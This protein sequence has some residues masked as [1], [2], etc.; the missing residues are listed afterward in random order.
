MVA[1]LK[2]QDA[3]T[4]AYASQYVDDSIESTQMNCGDF[5]FDPV[6]TAHN[7]L[8]AVAW[9]VQKKIHMPFHFLP[10]GPLTSKPDAFVTEPDSA[11]ANS[12]I[13]RALREA[14]PTSKLVALGIAMHSYAD[15]WAH[16]GFVGKD[17]EL[18]DVADIKYKA[19]D[20]WI[21][22]VA[23]NVFL[24]VLPKIGHAQASHYPDLPW[25]EWKYKRDGTGKIMK[26]KN[27]D[28]FMD[29]AEHI[30]ARLSG[31]DEA[32]E[33]KYSWND[34]KDGVADVL[35][36]EE[37]RIELR[38]RKWKELYYEYFGTPQGFTY[39]HLIWRNEAF[40]SR[41]RGKTEWDTMTHD[42]IMRTEFK[43]VK[44]FEKTRWVK[45]HRMALK[46]RNFVIDELFGG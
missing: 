45:F 33:K 5:Y 46:Q 26:R 40:D 43:P 4:I 38:I 12:V 2:K 28:L 18:N 6:R 27:V 35:A 36:Y 37:P 42:E 23:E 21:D 31:L 39:H 44:N 29:A 14:D 19:H 41:Y 7:G 16:A 22:P 32:T 3:L 1:G 34:I 20:E 9:T 30:H 15:T 10:K 13:E 24:D 11:L 17:D 8:G 25:I